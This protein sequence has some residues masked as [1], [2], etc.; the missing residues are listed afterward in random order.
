MSTKLSKKI[1][2]LRSSGLSYNKISKILNCSKS[3]ISYYCGINQKSKNLER[4]TKRRKN[5]SLQTKY[6]NFIGQK[7][8]IYNKKNISN[9]IH[10]VLNTKLHTF[11]KRG[12]Q[13]FKIND[14]IKKIGN[15]PKCYLTGRNINLEKSSTYSL[16]HIIPV[17]K[18]GDNSLKNCGLCCREA[19]MAKSDMTLDE[20]YKLCEDV[21]NNKSKP[22]F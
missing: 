3:T 17:S 10:K 15:N 13:M 16:D 8:I 14:L 11:C 22:S 19:N 18:G 20:F 4:Q 12:K 7:T 9:K 5:K 21:I 2:E 6:Y 1:I